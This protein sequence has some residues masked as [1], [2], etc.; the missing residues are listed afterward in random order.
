MNVEVHGSMA[1]T[2]LLGFVAFTL[3]YV[4]MVWTR[5]E[6]SRRQAQLADLEVENAI[7][8]RLSAEEVRI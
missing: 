7:R 8:E 5:F 3:A 2:L 4:W 6:T 1:W